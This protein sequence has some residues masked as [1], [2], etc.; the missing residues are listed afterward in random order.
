MHLLVFVVVTLIMIW[1][2]KTWLGLF[3]TLEE[4]IRRTYNWIQE[5]IKNREN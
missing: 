5:Q 4:G 2:G 3:Q 1:F